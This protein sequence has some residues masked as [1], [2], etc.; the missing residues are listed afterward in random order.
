LT[1]NSGGAAETAAAKREFDVIYDEG[2][3]MVK[4]PLEG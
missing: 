2:L 1:N 3:S 4:N